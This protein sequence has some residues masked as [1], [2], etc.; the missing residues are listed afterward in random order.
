MPNKREP[1]F[2]PIEA[3]C[4]K[5][6]GHTLQAGDFHFSKVVIQIEQKGGQKRIKPRGSPNHPC[7]T[8]SREWVTESGEVIRGAA[9]GSAWRGKPGAALGESFWDPR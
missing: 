5:V 6:T 1:E 8:C 3:T 4:W 9:E 2:K 7:L